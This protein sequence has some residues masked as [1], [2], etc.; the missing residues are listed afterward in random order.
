MS[1][2]KKVGLALG[3]GGFRGFAHIGV[4]K[5]LKKH[6]I[7]I[8]YLTGSSAGA[9]VAAHYAIF[10][11]EKKLEQD[12]VVNPKANVSVFF[13]L[14]RHGG[15]INGQ[16]FA[17]RIDQTLENRNFSDAKI[18]VKIATTDLISGQPFFFD[19]G[20]LSRAVRASSSVPLVFKPLVYR[21]HLLVDGA[22]SNPVP[23]SLVREMGADIVIAVNLYHRNEFV[24][25][26][27]TMPKVVLRSARIVLYNL[28]Q[29]DVK[30][31][32]LVID[33]DASEFNFDSGLKKYFSPA[34]AA[35]LVKIGE[36][37][38][39]RMIPTIKEKLGLSN[40]HEI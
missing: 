39:E 33:I 19:S 40:N 37:A 4:I 10:R 11:D 34:I 13:D 22:L 16:K 8:D 15:L 23:T 9:W 31:A 6:G 36:K 5:T 30:S 2:R 17:R 32:D 25:K 26:K 21:G 28:A 12:L 35:E 29:N 20:E 3:S 38:A 27:F 14:S 7:P 24:K 1:S 18:P